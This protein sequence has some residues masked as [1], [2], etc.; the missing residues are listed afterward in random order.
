MISDI[1]SDAAHVVRSQWLSDSR[2]YPPGDPL[3]ERINSLLCEIDEVRA[4]LDSHDPD[5]RKA[6]GGVA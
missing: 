6:K 4:E 2:M 5:T 1:L 3:T